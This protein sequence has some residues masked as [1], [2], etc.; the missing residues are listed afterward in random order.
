MSDILVGQHCTHCGDACDS[1][2]IVS[3][4]LLFCCSGCEMV[5]RILSDNGMTAYY[6]FEQTPGQS[7]RQHSVSSFAYLDEEA[8]S[9]KLL[10]FKENNRSKIT[11]HLPQIHCSS[12]LWLLEN[13]SRFDDAIISSR[14]NFL[15]KEATIL[16]DHTRLSLRGLAELMAK[17]GYEPKFSLDHLEKDKQQKRIDNTLVRKLG[18]A[19][20]AF[21]NIMLFK[22]SRV[23][24]IRASLFQNVSRIYQ[25][26]SRSSSSPL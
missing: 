17:I 12:C 18:Y 20:F 10:S 9:D 4:D 23:Y 7:M 13:I 2:A 25:S 21:G 24:G 6:T 1:N 15:T 16:Y 26:P 14:V 3:G 8:I 5:Y 19:G 22:F 11:L